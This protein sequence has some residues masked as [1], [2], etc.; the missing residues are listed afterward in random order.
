M[1]I[2]KYLSAVLFV[3]MLSAC[4]DDFLEPVYSGAATT[5]ELEATAK[6]NPEK[7]GYKFSGWSEIPETM[8]IMLSGTTINTIICKASILTINS[9]SNRE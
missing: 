3:G 5:D 2:T 9:F 7:Y 1:K 4:G 6:D 8:P